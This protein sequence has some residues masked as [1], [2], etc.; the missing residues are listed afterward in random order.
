M[1]A[2]RPVWSYCFPSREISGGV[3]DSHLIHGADL[4]AGPWVAT[5]RLRDAD[6]KLLGTWDLLAGLD[7]AEWAAARPDVADR[8]GFRAPDPWLSR[9]APDGTFFAQRFRARFS[10]AQPLAAATI[11]IRRNPDLPPDVELALYRVELRR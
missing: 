8:R 9:I 1:S 4:A 5:V 10:T 6:R 3:I 2:D 11:A 7:T